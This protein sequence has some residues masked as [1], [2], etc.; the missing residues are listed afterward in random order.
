M[1]F[2]MPSLSNLL[3]SGDGKKN[4]SSNAVPPGIEGSDSEVSEQFASPGG[5]RSYQPNSPKRTKPD[6]FNYDLPVTGA[7]YGV[8]ATVPISIKD[9]PEPQFHRTESPKMHLRSLSG[10]STGSPVLQYGADEITEQKLESWTVHNWSSFFQ[11]GPSMLSSADLEDGTADDGKLYGPE[12]EA[13]GAIWRLLV[14]PRG[15]ERR[16][17]LAVFLK[18]CGFLNDH[19]EKYSVCVDFKISIAN[20]HRI[21]NGNVE[22]EN[23]DETETRSAFDISNQTYYRFNEENNDWGFS[24]FARISDVEQLVA[25]N[26]T[27]TFNT[28]IT[29]LDDPVGKRWNEQFPWNSRKET[30]Y[31]GIRNQGATCYMNS[32]LQSLYFTNVLRKAIYQIPTQKDKPGESLLLALQ[33]FFYQLQT[34]EGCIDTTEL[35]KIFGWGFG[36]SLEHHDVQEFFKVLQDAIERKLKNF[37]IENPFDQIFSGKV[38]YIVKCINIDYTSK[39]EQP[40]HELILPISSGSLHQAIDEYTAFERIEGENGLNIEGHGRQD[41]MRGMLF[42]KLP[43]VLH[44]QLSRFVFDFARDIS[45]KLNDRFEFPT[46]L[47]MRQFMDPDVLKEEQEKGEKDYT[48]ELHAV[49]VHSGDSNVGHYYSFI[50]PTPTSGWYKFDDDRV[51]PASKE[52]AVDE[53]FGFTSGDSTVSVHSREQTVSSRSERVR[54]TAR[55]TNAYMLVYIRKSEYGQVLE[56]LQE[57]HLPKHV[58]DMCET[59]K[60]AEI[61]RRERKLE[62]LKFCTVKVMD[63]FQFNQFEGMGFCSFDPAHPELFTVVKLPRATGTPRE[64][65]AHLSE[66]NGIPTD[67]IRLWEITSIS[68]LKYSLASTP[69]LE[70]RLDQLISPPSSAG[71]ISSYYSEKRY[72]VDYLYEEESPEDLSELI[73]FVKG[74]WSEYRPVVGE[75]SDP[76]EYFHF[77]GQSHLSGLG[78]L[79]F[80]PNRPI[81][82]IVPLIRDM[83]RSREIFK[84]HSS[85][86]WEL[87]LETPIKPNKIDDKSRS[88]SYYVTKTARSLILIVKE[89]AVPQYGCFYE[90]GNLEDY[91]GYLLSKKTYFF[92]RR[93]ESDAEQEEQVSSN[94]E[95]K[96]EISCL[97]PPQQLISCVCSYLNVQPEYLRLFKEN[98]LEEL[99]IPITLA[100]FKHID[101][102]S[103]IG[104]NEQGI[105]VFLFDIL[106]SELPIERAADLV[107]INNIHLVTSKGIPCKLNTNFYVEKSLAL[108]ELTK[109]IAGQ[110]QPISFN[111]QISFIYFDI[112][113]DENM[114][115][116]YEESENFISDILESPTLY[117]QEVL[118]DFNVACFHYWKLIG[119]VHSFPFFSQLT[120]VTEGQEGRQ[121][122]KSDPYPITRLQSIRD[123]FIK[124]F[125]LGPKDAKVAR[126]Q[127]FF[128]GAET[129]ILDEH[130]QNSTLLF[131]SAE[132]I[133]AIGFEHPPPREPYRPQKGM[134]IK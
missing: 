10:R 19:A 44:I 130:S 32:M 25:P 18:F 43:L 118:G 22:D 117:C 6:G 116:I 70:N 91:V 11:E 12:F 87:F 93:S 79:K 35:I 60:R 111:P 47:D 62:E 119:N 38:R 89:P 84:H 64:L 3:G 73:V 45:V 82:D 90:L 42:E 58:V 113:L 14:F 94:S 7:E 15:N 75:H 40:F 2:G 74:F 23:E 33:T 36:E 120:K 129:V 112:D 104:E 48:Y 69:V 65:I 134:T 92:K 66:M 50:K 39:N 16:D 1:P 24:C 21:I 80:D 132:R 105:S 72:F 78:V 114:K 5:K 55:L 95:F 53:N 8:D 71:H 30:G 59:Q 97:A 81:A 17:F 54:L 98:A 133:R 49:M 101:E 9:G 108:S 46:T 68:S 77:P 28:L 61:E 20:P 106:P 126:V 27:L 41:I 85:N 63:C 109:R 88:L 107:Y 37:K 4:Q 102:V 34:S 128:H 122:S 99:L 110:Q 115:T 76:S 125:E 103:V 83:R 56:P 31:V 131:S 100:S 26:D 96:L 127:I 52:E 124:R 86:N 121:P 57:K 13:G 67:R 29:V 51:T 123:A